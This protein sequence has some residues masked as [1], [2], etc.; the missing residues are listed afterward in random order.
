MKGHAIIDFNHR[1]LGLAENPA[2]GIG[3]WSQNTEGVA[4]HRVIKTYICY[5]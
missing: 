3:F 1:V 5:D 2:R 4:Q